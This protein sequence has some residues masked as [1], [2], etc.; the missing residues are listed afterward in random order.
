MLYFFVGLIF[1]NLFIYYKKYVFVLFLFISLYMLGK[2]ISLKLYI[3]CCVVISIFLTF[4]INY[5]EDKNDSYKV[6]KVLIVEEKY[7]NYSIVSDENKKYLIYNNDN[8]FNE[9]NRVFFKGDLVNIKDTYN[10]FYN[11]LNK[12][13]VY[14]ELDYSYFEIIDYRVKYSQVIIDNLLENKSEQSKSYLKLILFNDKD[15]NNKA[16]YDNFSLYSLTYLIA[17]S[18]FHISLLLSFFK[19]IFKTNIVGLG[20]VSFYLYLLDFSISSYRAFLC[21]IF[22]KI[23]KKL[24]FDIS[25]LEIICLIGCV[26]LIRT[27]QVMFSF[28][29]IYSFLATLVLEIFK[30]YKGKKMFVMFYVYLV[31]I[32]LMLLNYYKLNL[33]SLLFSVV[34]NVPVSFLYVLSF[35]FLFL[36]K[37]YLLYE[38][39]IGLFYKFFN[40]LNE[41]N[42]ILVF[43][44]PSVSFVIVYYLVLLSFFLFK[45]R[46]SKLRFFYISVLFSLIIYQYYKPV[47]IYKE[48]V[49][50]L[51]VGQGDCSAFFVPHT[52]E[53]V[54]VDVGGSK[55]K[56]VAT[57]EIIPFLESKGINKIRKVIL[58]HDDFD[59]V[60]ALNSLKDN[61]YVQEVI[62]TSDFE[63]VIIGDRVFK[64]LNISEK[65]DNDGSLVLYGEYASYKLLLMGDASIDIEKKIVDEID[66]V[67]IIKIGHHGSNTSSDYEF[68]NKINGKIAIISVGKNNT[69]GHPHDDVVRNL[70]QLGY[71]ILRSDEN[72]DIGFGKNIFGLGFI[73]YFN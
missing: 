2:R 65:R 55:Y 69:Y 58:T 5:Y 6:D 51:N 15:E 71:I 40:V 14:Y 9:G 61:F 18:G 62:E 45:E 19:K 10:D 60:G 12:K 53:V 31:N 42:F 44:K 32:P 26:F 56:D 54:L 29:F 25:S 68:L 48:Q 11:Y 50:F 73:D 36:D 57:N 47:F 20:I 37:F 59:H 8:E 28:S 13:L 23:N 49:Y 4:R 24:D 72:N 52:K 34:L 1:T 41:F 70:K 46:K 27:P 66:G 21:Y 3:V 63:E 30:L 16:F 43:G 17:V 38:I 33:S 7:E 22:K 39:V 35:A 67:D 64:N